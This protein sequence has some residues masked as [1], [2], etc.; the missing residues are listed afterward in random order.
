MA[1][2]HEPAP[3]TYR[4]TRGYPRDECYGLTSRL[5]R[6]V[7]FIPANI[8]E[9]C[10][11]DSARD[12]A[13]FLHMAAGFAWELEYHLLRSRDVKQLTQPVYQDLSGR[14]SEVKRMLTGLIQRVRA[15]N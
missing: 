6:A 1:K 5:R 13:R 10:R 14:T 9:C 12:F 3:L 15:D 11:R 7:N 4:E 2:A 8:A